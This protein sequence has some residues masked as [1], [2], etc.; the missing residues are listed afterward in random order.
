MRVG[1]ESAEKS[2]SEARHA[3]QSLRGII[4]RVA[5]INDM[6]AQIARSANEQ[7]AV[8]EE[9]NQNMVSINDETQQI[10]DDAH[11]AAA[12]GEDISLMGM[13]IQN[14]VNQFQLK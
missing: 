2:V 10:A 5:N 8:V 4:D 13:E 14:K 6:N 12:S 11:R 3:S 7:Q 1:K 9:M